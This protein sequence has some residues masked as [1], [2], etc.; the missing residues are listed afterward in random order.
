MQGNASGGMLHTLNSSRTVE[1]GLG[2]LLLLELP[3][4]PA[5]IPLSMDSSLHGRHAQGLA[6]L[7]SRRSSDHQLTAEKAHSRS[8]RSRAHKWRGLQAC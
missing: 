4:L 6:A 5:R 7:S 8:W 2:W 3:S 1:V